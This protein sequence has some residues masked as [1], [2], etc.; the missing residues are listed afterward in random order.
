MLAQ[1][2]HHRTQAHADAPCRRCTNA[3]RNC[4]FA[5]PLTAM[6]SH[7]PDGSTTPPSMR[8]HAAD[9]PPSRPPRP[10][11]LRK[12]PP[13]PCGMP[14]IA[15]DAILPPGGDRILPDRHPHEV[16]IR[17]CDLGCAPI[18]IVHRPRTGARRTIPNPWRRRSS[19]ASP[20]AVAAVSRRPL[21][22]DADRSDA[23]SPSG[24][25]EHHVA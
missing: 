8:R 12:D 10:T 14:S 5:H 21:V 4:A 16:P 6:I 15:D 19:A 24:A 18:S 22:Q 23:W 13:L 20:H 11:S 7:H 2:F 1:G 9:H 3:R 17:I 25:S